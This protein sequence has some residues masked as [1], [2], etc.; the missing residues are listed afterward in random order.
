[1][2]R[3]ARI[4]AIALT[5]LSVLVLSRSTVFHVEP[6][7]IVKNAT[8]REVA[9][10]IAYAEKYA[11]EPNAEEFG[12]LGDVDCA[13]FVSQTLLARGW[14]MDRHWWQDVTA[15]IGSGYSRAWV[16]STAMAKY[17]HS[18][19]QYA[20]ELQWWQK[21]KVKVGDIVQFDWDASGDR[22]HTAIVTSI[23]VGPKGRDI[24]MA[25]HSRSKFNY[26][27]S[28]ELR[29]APKTTKV[30]YWSIRTPGTFKGFAADPDM[31]KVFG[32]NDR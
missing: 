14:K 31:P 21:D 11:F 1:M 7:F 9:A 8:T 13:N 30:Y 25:A 20:T 6:N 32:W 23:L 4:A 27:L 2:K 17:L 28:R 18:R 15:P 26:P 12:Y 10:Q 24:M 22:D 16:S 5:L 19:P 3:N 29:K